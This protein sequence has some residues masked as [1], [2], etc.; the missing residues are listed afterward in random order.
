MVNKYSYGGLS[1]A[2]LLA[3][4]IRCCNI[5]HISQYGRS[6]ATLM[7]LDAA[8]RQVFAPYCPGRRQGCQ[9]HRKNSFFFVPLLSEASIQ[10]AQN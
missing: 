4:T 8:I 7:S 3:T 2:V 9:Y 6:R 10:K 1:L 5:E